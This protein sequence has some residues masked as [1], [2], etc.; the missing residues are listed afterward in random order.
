M[1]LMEQNNKTPNQQKSSE[2]ATPPEYLEDRSAGNIELLGQHPNT[3]YLMP[4]YAQL[5]EEYPVLKSVKFIHVDT[6]H[7]MGTRF[8]N[9]GE[10][11]RDNS[12]RGYTGIP[13]LQYDFDKAPNSFTV[14]NIPEGSPATLEEDD[15][16]NKTVIFE[17]FANALGMPVGELCKNQKLTSTIV[18]LHELGHAHD[19]IV[20]FLGADEY[21]FA[22]GGVGPERFNAAQ[23]AWR[24]RN[25][26]DMKAYPLPKTK[27]QAA[28]RNKSFEERK[29]I[30]FNDFLKFRANLDEAGID[31]SGL[32]RGYF[33][34]VDL[35]LARR[36]RDG[37]AEKYADNFALNFVTK[38]RELFDENWNL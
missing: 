8:S 13:E 7:G 35:Q 9:V 34:D 16:R 31:T 14:E 1:V 15:K 2:T 22:Y 18:F 11:P 17:G 20:N 37:E 25:I 19:F 27:E 32:D 26:A 21:D 3:S 38:H 6:D 5:I 29:K 24:E 36:Y 23:A 4:V 12:E 28:A 30:L 10:S 33:Y